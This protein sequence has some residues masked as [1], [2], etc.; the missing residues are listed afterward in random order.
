[1]NTLTPTAGYIVEVQYWEQPDQN[2]TRS[3]IDA[4]LL[5]ARQAAFHY[6]QTLAVKKSPAEVLTVEIHLVEFNNGQAETPFLAQ[7]FK[8]RFHRS[9]RVLEPDTYTLNLTMEVSPEFDQLE[10]PLALTIDPTAVDEAVET[11]EAIF[12]NVS[13]LVIEYEYYRS[14]GHPPGFGYAIVGILGPGDQHLLD[15]VVSE[16]GDADAAMTE[17]VKRQKQT[18]FKLGLRLSFMLYDALGYAASLI[19]Q[20]NNEY[21]ATG[22]HLAF[23]VE[24]MPID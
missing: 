20:Y 21:A 13:G 19:G 9:K 10:S 22:E 8:R 1:M 14:Y 11:P 4:D 12:D 5:T 18:R 2:T 3:F 17:L 16:E 23:S 24:F 15:Q 6:A 7:V